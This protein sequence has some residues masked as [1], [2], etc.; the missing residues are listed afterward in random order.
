MVLRRRESLLQKGSVTREEYDN[1][2]TTFQEAEARTHTAEEA[3]R[4]AELGPRQEDIEAGRALLRAE[5]ASVSQAERRLADGELL[6]PG[7]GEILTLARE[8]GAIISPGETVFTLTLTTPVWVRTYVNE[9]DLG[10]VRPGHAPPSSATD[11]ARAR[12]TGDTSGSSRR[13]AEF[14]PKSVETP[15]LRTDL[16][17]RLRIIVDNPDGGCG[18]GCRSPSASTRAAKGRPVNTEPLVESKG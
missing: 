2:R 5:E 18:K 10:R 8:R 13:L 6:A 12:F 7:A 1:A 4:L 3:F 14:T 11:S 9:V 17:Y 15:E 16:V